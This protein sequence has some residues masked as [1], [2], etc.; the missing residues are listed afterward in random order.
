MCALAYE[1]LLL[2]IQHRLYMSFFE[3]QSSSQS[4]SV[5]DSPA[6]SATTFPAYTAELP[7]D[8]NI[9]QPTQE[10]LTSEKLQSDRE[11]AY[12]LEDEEA[13]NMVEGNTG[14]KKHYEKKKQ[15]S[16]KVESKK[17]DCKARLLIRTYS[18]TSTVLGNYNNT[19]N[20]P[21][22]DLNAKFTRLS[23]NTRVEIERL[24][25]LGVEPTKVLEQIQGGRV[26]EENLEELKDGKARRNE[27]A[28]RADI[29]RIQK[30]IE[31]ETIRLA[32]QDG[33]SVLQWV[34]NLREQG[35]YVELKTSSDKPPPASG[36]QPNAFV[37]VV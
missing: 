12:T 9:D 26:T 24:L 32:S 20:H 22:G 31:E 3:F 2:T 8:I 4:F 14:G 33:A 6:S 27:F 16:R 11:A 29:R 13:D 28:T 30:M 18:S 23:K 5:S 34:K 37:L 17:C 7:N 36:L 35:H 25:R 10:C 19:H 15:W 21:T 1:N